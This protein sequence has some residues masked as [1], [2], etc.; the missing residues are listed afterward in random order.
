[1]EDNFLTIEELRM[2]RDRY[3]TA[4]EVTEDI[5]N[6]VRAQR[7]ELKARIDELMD[8]N[9][10]V[11]IHHLDMIQRLKASQ[12]ELVA[13]VKHLNKRIEAAWA[14]KDGETE[15]ADAYREA[16]VWAMGRLKNCITG[17]H[18]YKDIEAVIDKYA[19]GK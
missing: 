11:P 17:G 18:E 9:C 12:Q 2:A 6:G 19:K 3:K 16:L 4:L 10:T 8:I 14:A 15:R 5:A 1:M 7:D 13:E